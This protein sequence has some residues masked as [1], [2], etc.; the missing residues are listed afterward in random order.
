M[1]LDLVKGRCTHQGIRAR[2]P[3]QQIGVTFIAILL[4][5]AALCSSAQ[6]FLQITFSLSFLHLLQLLD[7]DLTLSE[8]PTHTA[9]PVFPKF[10]QPRDVEEEMIHV[11]LCH[12]H[13][14]MCHSL[15]QHRLPLRLLSHTCVRSSA[16]VTAQ[17][18]SA[19]VTQ[20]SDTHLAQV[21]LTPKKI[22]KKSENHINHPKK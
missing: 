10:D 6:P 9:S 14:L 2:L 13:I 5:Q 7:K 22:T 1:L 21:D 17:L 20:K 8:T 15:Y 11:L 12:Y 4:F 16:A 19:A 18:Q 3:S